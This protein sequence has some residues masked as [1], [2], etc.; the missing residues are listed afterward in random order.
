MQLSRKM[1]ARSVRQTLRQYRAIAIRG[2][3]ID[4]VSTLH[5]YDESRTGSDVIVQTSSAATT[6]SLT[7]G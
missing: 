7:V 3:G 4:I 6:K 5:T 2:P 1:C